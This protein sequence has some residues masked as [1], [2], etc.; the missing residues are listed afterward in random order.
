MKTARL[1]VGLGFVALAAGTVPAVTAQSLP[2][3][4]RSKQAAT[5]A[6]DAT[7]AHTRAMTP[8]PADS[9]AS[10]GAQG[11]S[12]PQ[13]TAPGS[14]PGAPPAGAAGRATQS[15]AGGSAEA[16]APFE[17]EVYRYERA[18][19]RDPF[20]SLMENGDLRP[21]ITELRV[22]GI[23]FDENGRSSV[24]VLRDLTTKEQYRVRVGS[25]LGRMRVARIDRKTVTFTIEEFGFSR[26]E[27]LELTS[28]PNKEKQQ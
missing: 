17:R 24:A 20:V 9:T 15:T 21:L 12:R 7:N 11:A 18:G 26:Q 27:T 16:P 14:P 3:I 6:V 5:R 22:T 2:P 8:P 25:S 23:V 10:P 28:D 13:G 4:T 19:R 1:A